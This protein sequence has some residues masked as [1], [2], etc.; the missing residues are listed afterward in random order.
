[1]SLTSF[2]LDERPISRASSVNLLARRLLRLL[3]EPVNQHDFPA[4]EEEVDHAVDVGAALASQLPELVFQVADEGS[5]A[6]MFLATSW[7]IAQPMAC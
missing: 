6:R 2:V 3:L 1:M 5:R 7:S 4:G